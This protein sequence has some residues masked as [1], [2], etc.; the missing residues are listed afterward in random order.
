MKIVVFGATGG[1][2]ERIVERALAEGH[3]VVAVARKPEAFTTRHSRLKVVKGDVLDPASVATAIV[4]ADAVL[5][6]VGLPMTRTRA[7]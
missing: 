2:G 1:T 5:S 4:G 7:P 3:E 6:S